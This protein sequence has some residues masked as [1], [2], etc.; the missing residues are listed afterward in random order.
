MTR[1]MYLIAL[2]AAAFQTGCGDGPV[3]TEPLP[4][5]HPCAGHTISLQ[6]GD[7]LG[8]RSAG[9]ACLQPIAGAKYALAVLDGRGILSASHGPEDPLDPYG[10]RVA[11]LSATAAS[12]PMAAVATTAPDHMAGWAAPLEVQPHG[13]TI[14]DRPT[15]WVLGEEFPT[16]DWSN[17]PRTARVVRIYGDGLVVAWIDGD[18]S[19]L[20]EEFLGQLDQAIVPVR[21]IGL[22]LMQRT[23]GP[24][25]PLTSAGSGQYMILLM[26]LPGAR[27]RVFSFVGGDSVF[28]VMLLNVDPDPGPISLASLVAHELTHSYQRRYMH[29]TRPSGQVRSGFAAATWG[30]E[31]GANLISYEMIRRMAGI[32]IDGNFD[33][34][35]PDPDPVAEFYGLRA[36]PGNGEFNVG[37]DNAMGFFRHLIIQRM[38]DGEPLDDAVREVSR[39]AIEG[40]FGTDGFGA[41]RVGLATR[42][43]ERLG[44]AWQPD[45][46]LLDWTLSHAADDRTDNP[47]FQDH[48]SLRI[49]DIPVDRPYAW[50]P[51]GLLSTDLPAFTFV[52]GGGNPAYLYLEDDGTGLAFSIVSGVL[53]LQWKLIRVQ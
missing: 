4:D 35:A 19:D 52:R 39:G 32:P 45:L 25:I 28:S 47:A 10:V 13:H 41:R 46:A 20:I 7:T 9:R 30:A 14:Y 37:Y 21:D 12:V 51:E 49:W 48:A 24:G 16:R 36:Q 34:R 43:R 44:S 38:H 31:G 33:W 22:P 27:G 5:T 29:D 6:V 8:P 18:R 15:P 42:M 1:R 53:A 50:R 40:W 17:A 3:T 23:F 11:L 26:E 2:T